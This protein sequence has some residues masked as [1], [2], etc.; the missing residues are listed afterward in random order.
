MRFAHLAFD[1]GARHERRDRVD[2][3]DVDAAGADQHFDDFE[4]LFAVVGL[5]HQQVVDFDA[6]L[7]RVLGVERVLGIDECGHA[8]EALR[9][10]NHLQRERRLARR[11]RSEDFGDAAAGQPPDAERKVDADGAGRDRFGR[12][13]RVPLAESHDRA[14]AELLLDLADCDVERF[15][16]FL[17]FVH[18]HVLNPFQ[19]MGRDAP[20]GSNT[21]NGPG[22]SQAQ[23]RGKNR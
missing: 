8:P 4:R 16:S 20:T 12:G 19:T 23:I 9:L 13:D 17:A 14:L 21:R 10:G 22:E 11:F 15:E 1:F 7:L 18:W 3:D 5:R 2:D 6:E